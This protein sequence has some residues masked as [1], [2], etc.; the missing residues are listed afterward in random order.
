[1]KKYLFALFILILSICSCS[2]NNDESVQQEKE[3][4]YHNG[5]SL[6]NLKINFQMILIAF[7]ETEYSKNIALDILNGIPEID[8][9]KTTVAEYYRI[10]A[11]LHK[12]ITEENYLSL[13]IN[14]N[15]INSIDYATPS[16]Y[17]DDDTET[18]L[19]NKFFIEISM[20]ESEFSNFLNQ[21]HNRFQMVENYNPENLYIINNIIDG[22]EAMDISN[23]IHNSS[24]IEYSCPDFTRVKPDQ[25]VF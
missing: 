7:K 2:K 19:T 6:I 8:L 5:D 9:E 11:K 3:T 20:S 12:G 1:M 25:P 17:G 24:G 13:L 22:F 10:V 16:F 4:F 21:N 18:F 14:L 23:Q 15:S